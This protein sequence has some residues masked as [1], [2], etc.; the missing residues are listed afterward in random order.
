MLQTY[1]AII[2]LI[3]TKYRDFGMPSTQPLSINCIESS[4]LVLLKQLILKL[5]FVNK[6]W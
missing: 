6:K 3:L 4:K 2:A 1:T 5:L